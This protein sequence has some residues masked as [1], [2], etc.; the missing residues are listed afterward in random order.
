MNRLVAFMVA[1]FLVA[2][3]TVDAEWSMFGKDANHTGVSEITE[4]T[5]QDKEPVV[6]WDKGDS[7]SDEEVYSWGSVVG[8]FTS[9][10]IGDD[11]DRDVLHV[12]YITA[13][14]INDELRGKLVIWD[15]GNQEL[16]WEKDIGLIVDQNGQSI[17]NDFEA[18]DSAYATPAIADFDGDG[19]I[20]IAI[21]KPSGEVHF[22]EPE[23]EYYSDNEN[24]DTDGNSQFWSYDS[25]LTVV[26]S[27]PVVTNLNGGNDL[28]FSGIDLDS[29]PDE[30]N[31][32][33]V[34]GSTGVRLWQ[35]IASGSEVSSPVVLEDSSNRKIFVSVYDSGNLKVYGIQNGDVLSDWDGK[36]LA[37]ILN[38]ND[39]AHH[40]ILPSI[41]IADI[42]DDM[43]REILVP[44][45][46]ST[47]G[48][49]AQLWLFK[50]DGT[51]A[52]D[53][54]EPYEL[55]SG[56]DIDATPA[57]GD[58]DADG[59][60]EIVAVTW[61]DEWDETE[62]THVWSLHHDSQFDW[63][64]TY[65][66]TNSGA[67]DN[68]EHAIS[69][70]ILAVIFDEDGSS[71]LDVFSCTTP[72]C[73][74]LD[75]HDGGNGDPDPKAELWD[76]SLFNRGNDNRIYNSPAASDVDGDG[77]LDIIID[78]SVYSAN[79]ADLTLK[80]KDIKITD[81]EGKVVTEV[82]ENQVVVFYPITIRNEG[83]FQ[84][85]NV[86]VEVRLDTKEGTIIHEQ[87]ISINAN[88]VQN[89]DEF[90]WTAEGQGVHKIWILCLI[91]ST[92]NEEVRY[93]NNNMSKSLLVRPQYGLELNITDKSEI[94]D[95]NQEANFI[96]E[97]KNVGL[98]SDNYTVDVS[99]MNPKWVITYPSEVNE[100]GGN[101][102]KNFTVSFV[103]GSNVTAAEHLFTI[104]VTSEGNSSRTDSEIVSIMINQY[105]GLGVVM[106]LTYQRA[107]PDTDITY[108]VRIINEG[109]GID[110]FDLFIE[111]DVDWVADIWVDNS[112]V[113]DI[114]IGAF[115][116]VDAEIRL[117]TPSD[118][119]PGDYK[120][121][122]LS[123]VSQG[124]DSFA[125]SLVSNTSIGIMMAEKAVVGVLP[126]ENVSFSVLFLNPT[127]TTDSFSVSVLSGAP[128]W[129]SSIFP[130][131]VNLSTFEEGRSWINFTAPNTAN[132]GDSF[133]IQLGFGNDEILD[134]ITVV[135]EVNTIQGI[136]LWS[137]DDRHVAY[138]D[139]GE[140]VY[141]NVRVVNYEDQELTIDL[142]HQDDFIPEWDVAY[143]TY[144]S[145]SKTIPAGSS[146][147]VNITITSPQNAEAIVTG[148]VRIIGTVSG[149]EP[150]FFDV[151]VTINQTFGISISSQSTITLLGNVS[152]LVELSITNTGNGPDTFEVKYFGDWIDNNTDLIHFDGFETQK[153][154]FIV[155]S[156]VFGPGTQGSVFVEVNSSKSLDT[157]IL[158][159]QNTTLS[160][161]VTGLQAI[162]SSSF[163]VNL[164]EELSFQVLMVSLIDSNPTS[165]LVTDVSGQAQYWVNFNS[166]EPFDVDG[167]DRET[168]VVTVGEPQMFKVD[169]LVPQILEA[170]EYTFTLEITDYYN[171]SHVSNLTYTINVLQEYDI[172]LVPTS[173]PT[174]SNPGYSVEWVLQITNNGNGPDTINMDVAGF[175]DY[176]SYTFHSDSTL[177]LESTFSSPNLKIIILTVD[178][179]D[180]ATSGI[181]NFLIQ[182]QSIG[183]SDNL[184]VNFTV[185][186]IYKIQAS[187]IGD[188]DLVGTPG[189]DPVY[190]QFEVANLGNT[191]DSILIEYAGTLDP[192]DDDFKWTNKS[193]S[194]DE[195]DDNY[196][197]AEVP[198]TNNGPW[199]AIVKISSQGNP[200]ISSTIT[201]TLDGYALP[202]VGIR[203][204]AMMPPNPQP[205]EKVKLSFTITA[206]DADV[207]SV[208]YTVYLDG[209][210]Y[211]GDRVTGISKGG[212]KP[213]VF[214][215]I[216]EEGSHTVTVRLDESDELSD[217]K[218]DNNV[219]QQDF[220]VEPSS[221][222]NLALYLIL[223]AILSVSTAVYYRY[224]RREKSETSGIRV[225]RSPIVSESSI[226]F[227]LVLN[228]L[229]CGSRVRV[230]RPGSFRCPSCKE[231][232]DVDSNGEIKSNAKAE[233]IVR[234]RSS[235]S[236]SSESIP[237][238]EAGSRRNRMEAFLSKE[239]SEDN[240]QETELEKLSASER[241]RR[242]KEEESS[243]P[244]NSQEEEPE[245]EEEISEDNVSSEEKP[246][247]SK[248]KKRKDPPKGGSFGPTVGGF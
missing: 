209:V 100:I 177:N 106:P 48:G 192:I 43:G 97:I 56:G 190:F 134:T 228:C 34:D 185:N 110:T 241:L 85:N 143:N 32:I 66:T 42:T 216:A 75:G 108:P 3:S 208:Y 168:Y 17:E 156:G 153:I 94:V 74:A 57:V 147:T 55:T 47:S 41:V 247:S 226:S 2:P 64:T 239:K 84:A 161:V 132:P 149:F 96:F 82:E 181:Y 189:G 60:L 186:P 61:S 164:G 155:N 86:D 63:R 121:L 229:Q 118:G 231:V 242:L 77:L 27:S 65:D 150:A 124:N 207:P 35:F 14:M 137:I 71:N 178:V 50:S 174:S 49:D 91:D 123:V 87:T 235:L 116:T 73:Y 204:L 52:T 201:F 11:Y 128:D 44:Q 167:V 218:I 107:F 166:T 115:R 99:V 224:S 246:N 51:D 20:D 215:F 114:S 145:W 230:A 142:S 213:I 130:E 37:S 176:W 9:N 45:P 23:I 78:G 140:T 83:N 95:V 220:V 240:S 125:E 245:I 206:E 24:Y 90:N 53:W 33:A 175:P 62:K 135:L 203:D 113:T 222:S 131:N 187:L 129:D 159:S 148:W 79:L 183:S 38:P 36:S 233:T 141:F 232:S 46:P 234:R 219:A 72:D 191:D 6:S 172:S 19:L 170:G 92:Q 217:P 88:T 69:S 138:S 22:Y 80:R 58:L 197:R 127:N 194:P 39:A 221:S 30:I 199:T 244:E 117:T 133:V 154:S 212:S 146:T 89:L 26:R 179:P 7:S 205:G 162:G 98:Q 157:D 173:S 81:T 105:Y 182:A 225:R 103:P 210:V 151:N 120:E 139:P 1:L 104:S 67:G 93:D 136:R 112:P 160:F 195:T 169:I 5:I 238:P 196:L 70:P 188:K 214:D 111:Y 18:F 202:D 237:K 122:T 68:D 31:V 16:M 243:V 223:F 28:I 102:T 8:N 12:V 227:P 29:E 101:S 152:E 4:R 236:S 119:D 76:I 10:I 198:I 211:G 193:F 158:V 54:A 163:S 126:G 165:R 21:I 184:D 200:S 109:N 144:N 13:E 40:P 171:S 180:N 25:D 15:G 248:S 59:D